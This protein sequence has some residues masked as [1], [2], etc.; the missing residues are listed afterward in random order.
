MKKIW[1]YLALMIAMP[2]M[3][4]AAGTSYISAKDVYVVRAADRESVVSQQFS[5]YRLVWN[6]DIRKFELH[7]GENQRPINVD[8]SL[9]LQQ[10]QPEPSFYTKELAI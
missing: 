8:D 5:N 1:M 2:C 3:A 6:Q 7:E 10:D 4:Y 9:P